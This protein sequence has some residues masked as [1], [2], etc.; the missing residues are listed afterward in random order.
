MLLLSG[1]ENHKLAERVA[2]KLGV[3]L[4]PVTIEHFED[5]ETYVNIRADIAGQDVAI[6]QSCSAPTNANLMELLILLDAARRLKPKSL[7]AVVPFLAYRRQIQK[8]ESGESVTAELVARLIETAGAQ[9]VILVDVHHQSVKSFFH[10]PVVELS[11]F[12]AIVEKFRQRN[13]GKAVVAAPDRGARDRARQLAEALAVPLVQVD[14]KRAAHDVVGTMV[15]EGDVAGKDVYILD[16]EVN[17]GGTLMKVADLLKE[18]GA[19]KIICACT[20]AVLSGNAAGRIQQSAVDE[21][22]VADTIYLPQEKRVPKIEQ[23][24]VA[25]VIA[26]TLRA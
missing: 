5:G 19:A 25:G 26:D 23:V 14:K 4:S 20:H 7:T 15:L 8:H 9:K 18:K 13:L 21:L 6:L 17:T 3:V 10:V 12:A 24:S 1:L 2:E 16:D 11:A 22:I